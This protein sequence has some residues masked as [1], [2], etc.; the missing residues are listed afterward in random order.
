MILQ[1]CGEACRQTCIKSLLC[2]KQKSQ[3]D[4]PAAVG[5]DD[6]Q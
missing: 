2:V 4:A 5:D 6:L 1:S 3:A